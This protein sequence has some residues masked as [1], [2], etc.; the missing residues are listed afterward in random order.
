MSQETNCFSASIY[1]DGK[2]V[3]VVSNTGCGGPHDYHWDDREASKQIDA[4]AESLPCEFDFEK[5]D[6]FI[7]S[8]IFE[9]QS[10][11]AIKK[12]CKGATVFALSGDVKH[13]W[14]SIKVPYSLEVRQQI[15]SKYPNIAIIANDDMILASRW[16]LQSSKRTPKV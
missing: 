2:R 6:Q 12:L 5:L 7:D 3:G 11:K 9:I 10:L 16:Y 15:L 14:M 1:L 13:A 8:K 4:Y